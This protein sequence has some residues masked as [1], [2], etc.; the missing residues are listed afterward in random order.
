[1]H[2]VS[3]RLVPAGFP[4]VQAAAVIAL[5]RAV[6]LAR[7]GLSL[8]YA[9]AA[10]LLSG[11][12][13]DSVQRYLVPFAIIAV[14]TLAETLVLKRLASGPPRVALV[15]ADSAVAVVL[16]LVWTADPVYVIYQIGAAALAGAML[17]LHSTP[18]WGGQAIQAVATCW[19]VLADK[20]APPLTTLA[21][22]TAPALIVAAGASAVTITRIVQ[23]RLNRDLD[24]SLPVPEIHRRTRRILRASSFTIFRS[25]RRLRLAD[26]LARTLVH[27]TSVAMDH[28]GTPVNGVRFDYDHEDFAEPL[29]A[30]CMEWAQEARVNMRTS[31]PPVWLRIPVRHQLALIVDDALSNVAVHSHATR[32]RVELAE[33]RQV[34]TLTIADNGRGFVVPADPAVLKGGHYE[35]IR[36]MIDRSSFLG[37]DLTISSQPHGGTEI[38]V[39]MTGMP[40]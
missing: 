39:R 27:D 11:L 9:A 8:L 17:G 33:R 15:F 28:A 37:A 21:L 14:V 38:K 2:G 23:E 32:A 35:G 18:L 3:P 20:I 1:M 12:N 24:P 6:L 5:G 29:D 22:V 26:E 13:P 36:R 7:F 34:V 19:V 31:L 25:R 10:V 30:L 4:G 16:F 40:S